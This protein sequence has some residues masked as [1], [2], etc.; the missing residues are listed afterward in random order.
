MRNVW[1][2]YKFEL[3]QNTPSF[4][5]WFTTI[6][7]VLVAFMALFPTFSSSQYLELINAKISILPAVYARG[8]GI[9]A[10]ATGAMFQQIFFWYAYMFQFYIIAIIIYAINLG[11]GIVAKE[12][13]EKHI[14]YLATK[15]IKKSLI[16]IVKYKVLIT[17]ILLF[18][19]LLFV[20][21]IPVLVVFDNTNSQF[22]PQ[23][24][25]LTIKVFF[26]YVFFGTLA[27]SIS[28]INKKTARLS[29][30]V[31]GLFFVSYLLGIASSVQ[32]Q[33]NQ[34]VYL[35]PFFMFQSTTAGQGF[36]STDLWYMLVLAILS[37]LMFG[38]AVWRYSTKDLSL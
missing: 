29:I 21:S 37:V 4:L 10:G 7:I 11:S 3:R 12:H 9:Q 17:Y 38:L 8:F 13:S 28:A 32:N 6:T 20:I 14:D 22:G 35:S 31:I 33:L 24:V 5:V 18:T 36:S 34:L 27:F 2:L 15:P 30:I 16:I 26:E 25:R 1:N 19:V 23:L